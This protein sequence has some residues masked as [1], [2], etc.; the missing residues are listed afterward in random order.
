L[1]AFF[2]EYFRQDFRFRAGARVET[3]PISGTFF[4]FSGDRSDPT[5]HRITA[6][7]RPFLYFFIAAP[8]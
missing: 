5:L 4:L 2:I 3:G 1:S 7:H 8:P 6:L